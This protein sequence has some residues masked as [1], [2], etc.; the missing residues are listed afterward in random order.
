MA[1]EPRSSILCIFIIQVQPSG[2]QGQAS[3]STQDK[4]SHGCTHRWQS[5]GYQHRSF[6]HRANFSYTQSTAVSAAQHEQ[7]TAVPH[8][9]P[10]I[11]SCHA[12]NTLSDRSAPKVPSSNSI[13]ADPR[14]AL[15]AMASTIMCSAADGRRYTAGNTRQAVHSRQY[16][17]ID[18]L[19]CNL[20]AS[21]A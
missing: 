6:S 11:Q 9:H 20:P 15:S 12:M 16:T 17:A 8:A 10:S 14:G 1:A 19:T 2:V 18:P 3:C 7:S 4:A 13:A 5:P 21:K